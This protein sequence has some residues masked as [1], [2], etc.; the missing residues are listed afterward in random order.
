MSC[1]QSVPEHRLNAGVIQKAR[2]NS[3]E[4]LCSMGEVYNHWTLKK[5]KG[6]RKEMG[7]NTRKKAGSK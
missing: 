6:E 4:K 5:E 7:I 3:Q 1:T 2:I